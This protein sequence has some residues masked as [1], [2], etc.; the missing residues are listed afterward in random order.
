M[1]TPH[2]KTDATKPDGWNDRSLILYS[3]PNKTTGMDIEAN[4]AI[5]RDQMKPDET[6][7]DF[8]KRQTKVMEEE[9]P[10]FD[11]VSQ[12]KGEM[13]KKPAFDLFC[14]WMTPAG[15]VEQRVVF[16]SIGNGEVVTIA[17]TSQQGDFDNHKA[18][19][20]EI[21]ASLTLTEVKK[22]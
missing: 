5:S 13:H 2:I 6:F 12:R 19:F 10:Q 14:S 22:S 21:L 11:S 17:M 3:N 16:I 7:G 20:N 9:I 1:T 18:T 8:I 4:V 15:R